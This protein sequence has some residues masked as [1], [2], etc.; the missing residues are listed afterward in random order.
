MIVLRDENKL[1]VGSQRGAGG[2]KRYRSAAVPA[3]P[4]RKDIPALDI[5][6]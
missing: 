5:C 2:S 6:N 3:V 1:Q 4:N